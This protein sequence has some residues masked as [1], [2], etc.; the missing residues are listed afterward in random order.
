MCVQL[1]CKWDLSSTAESWIAS[2]VFIGM[3]L[4]SYTWG[5]LSDALGRRLGFLAPA[6]FTAIFGIAS[7]FS[8]NY[9][10]CFCATLTLL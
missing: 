2:A 10:V 9:G 4:G 1:K 3:M 6:C 5:A 8:P 7:A